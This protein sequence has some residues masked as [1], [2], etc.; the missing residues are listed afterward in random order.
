MILSL[1]CDSDYIVLKKILIHACYEIP[2]PHLLTYFSSLHL[3]FNSYLDKLDKETL[4]SQVAHSSVQIG[5][6]PSIK[7]MVDENVTP[8]APNTITVSDDR[9]SCQ[10]SFPRQKL[11]ETFLQIDLVTRD[12]IRRIHT[13][14]TR[15][16]PLSLA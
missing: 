7:A 12:V 13:L 9:S 14:A 4:Q 16:T 6:T 1:Y 10:S 2:Y 8:T 3:Q 11:P 5:F 15:E